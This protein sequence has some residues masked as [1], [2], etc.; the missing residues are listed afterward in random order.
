MVFG[1]SRKQHPSEGKTSSSSPILRSNSSSDGYGYGSLLCGADT[2]TTTGTFISN[3]LNDDVIPVYHGEKDEEELENQANKDFLQGGGEGAEVEEGLRVE[4]EMILETPQEVIGSDSNKATTTKK[5]PKRMTIVA[6]KMKKKIVKRLSSRSGGGRPPLPPS[7]TSVVDDIMARHTTKAEVVKDLATTTTRTIKYEETMSIEKDKFQNE[8]VED[9]DK[10]ARHHEM[11]KKS[12][13]ENTTDDGADVE[14]ASL[15]LDVEAVLEVDGATS[16]TATGT[17]DEDGD[18][19]VEDEEGVHYKHSP[20]EKGVERMDTLGNVAGVTASQDDE[21]EAD[22]GVVV[23]SK[24]KEMNKTK[25]ATKGDTIATSFLQKANRYY[26]AIATRG[27]K[28]SSKIVATTTNATT[29]C[30]ADSTCPISTSPWSNDDGK[31]AAGKN[32]R[33]SSVVEKLSRKIVAT[34]KATCGADTCPISS[35]WTK[36]DVDDEVNQ[37][38]KM[39]SYQGDTT[40]IAAATPSTVKDEES[41]NNSP[42]KSVF[43]EGVEIYRID[44]CCNVPFAKDNYDFFLG[45]DDGRWEEETHDDDFTSAYSKSKSFEDNDQAFIEPMALFAGGSKLMEE[46][47]EYDEKVV[48]DKNNRLHVSEKNSVQTEKF[49]KGATLMVESASPPTRHV[50]PQVEG[51]QS[52]TTYSRNHMDYDDSD[53]WKRYTEKKLA[54]EAAG[55]E[56]RSKLNTS[57]VSF[58]GSIN[59]DKK[60]MAMSNVKMESMGNGTTLFVET[61]AKKSPD[62]KMESIGNGTTL[63]VESST[64][65]TTTTQKQKIVQQRRE[66]HEHVTKATLRSK[67]IFE[68]EEKKDDYSAVI[69]TGSNVKMKGRTA[70]TVTTSNTVITSNSVVTKENN[71][72]IDSDDGTVERAAIRYV[73][74]DVALPLQKEI[75]KFVKYNCKTINWLINSEIL[76]DNKNDDVGCFTSRSCLSNDEDDDNGTKNGNS[77]VESVRMKKHRD[78]YYAYMTRNDGDTFFC[79]PCGGQ[80]A[81]DAFCL[82]GGGGD[83]DSLSNGPQ[84]RSKLDDD[85]SEMEGFG[86][87]KTTTTPPRQQPTVL[88]GDDDIEKTEGGGDDDDEITLNEMIK[89]RLLMEVNK[90]ID[91]H[92]GSMDTTLNV[93]KERLMEG[94][95]NI[96]LAIPIS[97]LL[98][99]DINDDDA[100]DD[101]DDSGDGKSNG[102]DESGHACGIPKTAST[103]FPEFSNDTEKF[104][105]QLNCIV[106]NL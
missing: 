49:G 85:E 14:T 105:D 70:S 11:E 97:Q 28:M 89:E 72:D 54:A 34:A 37:R 65:A 42:A 20:G 27:E 77:V 6:K 5:T 79:T 43:G 55:N 91:T 96:K 19:G 21:N 78:K 31:V 75:T 95:N 45:D 48:V 38:N 67:S 30:V 90:L 32:Q 3:N 53:S 73:K 94:A 103:T 1:R 47:E 22:V 12:T 4:I 64:S 106:V 18:D 8:F 66:E 82:N 63:F 71:D 15:L 92:N 80:R 46:T 100:D 29:S 69:P 44:D 40:N 58:E 13:I 35:P 88:E 68:D 10:A 2:T 93:I 41:S 62:V 83:N 25:T 17:T 39:K 7:P 51:Q 57:K 59:Q 98:N 61:P 50:V 87:F 56:N 101:D 104:L 24:E 60:D 26:K 86:V 52:T 74:N 81:S 23:G 76:G 33:D 99:T 9:F 16:I 36:E 84:N 102:D